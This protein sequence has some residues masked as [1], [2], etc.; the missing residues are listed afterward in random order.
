[1]QRRKKTKK[2]TEDDAVEGRMETLISWNTVTSLWVIFCLYWVVSALRVKRTQQ[3]EAAGRRFGTVAILVVAAFL[4]FA[5]RANLGILSRRFT[6]E[7]ETIKAASIVLVAVGVAIAIWARRHIGEYWSSRVA[8]KEDHHL[9]Q[10]GPYARVRHP[11]YSGM[12][13]AMIGTGLF[14]GEWRAIIG[15]LLVF[16]AHWQKARRE[17]KLLASEFGPIYQ[18][19]CGRTG[20]LIPRLH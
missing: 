5:R 2:Q 13:L 18:E 8:L 3:M 12:L 20:S 10:S 7:S 9:I 4:I 1:M 11:I 15:V 6:P 16:A 17:E 19:Y 14:V